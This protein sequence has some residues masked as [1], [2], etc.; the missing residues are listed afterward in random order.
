[1]TKSKMT[2]SESRPDSNFAINSASKFVFLLN[3]ILILNLILVQC[4]NE[5]RY[6]DFFLF[7]ISI[8]LNKWFFI[9]IFITKSIVMQ[10]MQV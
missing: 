3:L 7:Y 9:S 2:Y 4:L 10:A 6:L 1:M 5:S 8:L